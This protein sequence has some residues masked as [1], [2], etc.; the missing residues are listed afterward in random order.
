MEYRLT[1]TVS[2]YG[3]DPQNAQVFLKS[4]YKLYPEAG[5]VADQ[6]LK[7]GAL[8]V[9]FLFDAGDDLAEASNTGAGM[10][11]EAAN[12]SGLPA[13]PFV[14]AV[15]TPVDSEAEEA[16]LPRELEYA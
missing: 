5:A 14:E 9:T 4:F 7:T 16:E 12:A 10:F 13:T 6:N 8:S 15:L 3:R 2:E 1:V 11:V